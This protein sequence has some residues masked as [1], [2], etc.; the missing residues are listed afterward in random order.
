MDKQTTDIVCY[1]TWIGFLIA[2]CAGTKEESKFHLNQALVL[3]IATAIGAIIPILGWLIDL[4]LFVFWI[5]GLVSAIN[6]EEK[7]IPLLG[8]IHILK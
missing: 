8:S 7:P 5:M 3:I 6:G 1:L 2:L 4:V